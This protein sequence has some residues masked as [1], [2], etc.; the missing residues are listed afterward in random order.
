[1]VGS[2]ANLA[3][4][5]V[6]FY[7]DSDELRPQPVSMALLSE[8][9]HV[10][11]GVVNPSI[12]QLLDDRGSVVRQRIPMWPYLI[13]LALLLNFAELALRRGFVKWPVA[14]AR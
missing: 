10:T 14:R 2:D 8:I 5:E 6:G 13:V 12:E 11:G 4:P 3:L 1:V 7:R 9:S